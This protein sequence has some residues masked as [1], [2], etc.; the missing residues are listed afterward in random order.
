MIELTSADLIAVDRTPTFT[1]EGVEGLDPRKLRDT[2]VVIDGHRYLVKRVE[3][4]AL[5][6]ATGTSFGLAVERQS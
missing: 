1:F 5:H 2:V 3:T 4:F 6:D